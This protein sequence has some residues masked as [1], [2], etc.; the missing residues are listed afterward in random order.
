MTTLYWRILCLVSVC[1][2][3]VGVVVPG[4]PTVP[5]MILGAWAASKAWPELEIWLLSHRHYG[6]YIRQWR[7]RGAIPRRA[8]IL[9][10]LMMTASLGVLF[11]TGAHAGLILALAALMAGV[12]FWMW[13]RPE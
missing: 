1:L 9:A 2:G 5:F 8:K 10:G 4:L 12:L 3:L 13:S 6:P 11:Y 7:E